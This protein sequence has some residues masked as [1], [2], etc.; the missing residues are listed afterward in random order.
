MSTALLS[1]GATAHARP[2][3]LGPTRLRVTV[4]HCSLAQATLYSL[5][6]N[7]GVDAPKLLYVCCAQGRCR[8][9]RKSITMQPLNSVSERH[10]RAVLERD[11]REWRADNR[12][13]IV[14]PG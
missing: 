8:L 6:G 10:D 1:A 11:L 14:E 13:V 12:G 9:T 7:R 4:T 5:S 3:Y 2:D